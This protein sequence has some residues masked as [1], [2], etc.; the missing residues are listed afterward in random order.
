M[1]TDE[2]ARLPLAGRVAIVIGASRGIG[3]AI[4]LHLASL[5]ARLVLC[6]ASNA[7]QADLLAAQINSSSSTSP[8]AVAV[9]ADVSVPADVK[10]LFDRAESAFASPAHMLVS[11]AGYGRKWVNAQVVRVNGEFI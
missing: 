10:Y 6:Y 3:R 2:T 9:R 1:A 8:R 4:S 7:A 11:C 5:G